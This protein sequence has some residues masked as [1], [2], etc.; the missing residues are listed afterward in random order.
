MWVAVATYGSVAGH[1]ARTVSFLQQWH[2]IL[3]FVEFDDLKEALQL[4]D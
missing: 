3:V 2:R 1:D 4:S